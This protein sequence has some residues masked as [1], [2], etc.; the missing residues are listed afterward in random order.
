MLALV[1]LCGRW[2]ADWYRDWSAY[3]WALAVMVIIAGPWFG[4]PLGK[5]VPLALLVAVPARPTL[6][7]PVVLGLPAQLRRVT[8]PGLVGVG[9]W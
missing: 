4:Y 8:R 5:L 3:F 1:I 9:Y 2:F 7:R 6:F